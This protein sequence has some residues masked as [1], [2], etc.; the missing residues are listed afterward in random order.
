MLVRLGRLS[1]VPFLHREV[2][3]MPRN[4]PFT[5]LIEIVFIVIVNVLYVVTLFLLAKLLL[6]FAPIFN[7]G[8]IWISF[9]PDT[10]L[11]L[12]VEHVVFRVVFYDPFDCECLS[13]LVHKLLL[14]VF[15]FS[16]H[17][18]RPILHIIRIVESFNLW[19]F[20]H[21]VYRTFIV[22]ILSESW[23]ALLIKGRVAPVLL[24]VKH[25][26]LNYGWRVQFLL[27]ILQLSKLGFIFLKLSEPL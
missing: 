22:I 2:V 10:L 24:I 9:S 25:N 8:T 3:R 13:T 1:F 27:D 17:H 11:F 4:N 26:M 15:T 21:S 5:R 14:Y 12:H 20:G 16:L 23:L 7:F 18:T 6:L 19:N